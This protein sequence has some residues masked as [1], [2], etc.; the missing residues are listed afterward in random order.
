MQIRDPRSK[1]EDKFCY[2]CAYWCGRCMTRFRIRIARDPVCDE[3]VQR[4]A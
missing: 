3:F 1:S 4:E 2:D